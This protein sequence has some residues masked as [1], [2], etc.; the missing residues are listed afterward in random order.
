MSLEKCSDKRI[1]EAETE[2]QQVHALHFIGAKLS[3][4]DGLLQM[5]A[6]IW[7]LVCSAPQFNVYPI[8]VAADSPE[9][10]M[11]IHNVKHL[12]CVI[13]NKQGFLG[14]GNFSI[15]ALTDK[16]LG[17][18]IQLLLYLGN[19]NL[20]KNV[21]KMKVR[22]REKNYGLCINMTERSTSIS[23]YVLQN[24]RMISHRVMIIVRKTIGNVNNTQIRQPKF[25]QNY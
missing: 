14:F 22:K 23:K 1:F 12:W 8:F 16:A 15:P 7:S 24:Y 9:A 19:Q 25:R 4:P 5:G 13:A 17:W 21:S 11:Q 20:G 18:E 3:L 6:Q 10:C 2:G